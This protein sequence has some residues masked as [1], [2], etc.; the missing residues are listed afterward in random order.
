MLYSLPSTILKEF[1]SII[2]INEKFLFSQF[3]KACLIISKSCPS[4]DVGG[5][6][7][8]DERLSNALLIFG[9]LKYT[10]S[11]EF[12]NQLFGELSPSFPIL[13]SLVY[14]MHYTN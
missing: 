1:I 13:Y 5:Y 6:L 2:G 14:K 10:W 7:T 4:A 11:T 3:S 8:F 9:S 12:I